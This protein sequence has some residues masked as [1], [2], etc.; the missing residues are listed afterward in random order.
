VTLSV[1]ESCGSHTFEHSCNADIRDG[2]E[3]D[4]RIWAHN[5]GDGISITRLLYVLV[6]GQA[7][8]EVGDYVVNVRVERAH[9]DACDGP[10]DITGGGTVFGQ[11]SGIGASAAEGSC[12]PLVRRAR[13]EGVLLFN[14]DESRHAVLSARAT[15]F[16]PDL[17]V[18]A[19]DCATGTELDCDAGSS[20]GGSGA[21][22][23][24]DLDVEPGVKHFLFV[25]G[26]TAGA[27]YVVH[28]DPS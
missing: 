13:Q 24:L 11:V 26:A 18:R 5:L 19:G 8:R 6:K 9:G 4:A 1:A 16:V 21:T 10:L 20:G 23:L 14:G 25:D 28:Y 22:A 12:Q 27:S 2:V 3:R 15:T 17:Y 7:A